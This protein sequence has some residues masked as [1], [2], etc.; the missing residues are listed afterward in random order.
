V[1]RGQRKR[2]L[3]EHWGQRSFHGRQVVD[4]ALLDSLDLDVTTFKRAAQ[5][6]EP[7][8]LHAYGTR[9]GGTPQEVTIRPD[10][11]D[12][13][14]WAGMTI[15][16]FDFFK[17]HPPLYAFMRALREDTGFTGSM[18]S[19]IFFSPP[20]SG[21][22][23]HFD[24]TA[25]INLQ[26]QGTKA[27]HFGE[28]P[29][30]MNPPIGGKLADFSQMQEAHSWFRPR[31]PRADHLQS[32]TLAPGDVLYLAPGTWHDAN[33]NDVSLSVGLGIRPL[34]RAKRL[35][36]GLLGVLNDSEEWRV[37]N[38]P[39][40]NGHSHHRDANGGGDRRASAL[41]LAAQLEALLAEGLEPPAIVDALEP[42]PE[43]P[44]PV[45]GDVFDVSHPFRFSP[46]KGAGSDIDVVT[47]ARTF[48]L[49]AEALPLLEKLART[50]SFSASD[51]MRWPAEERMVDSWADVRLLVAD[52]VNLGLLRPSQKGRAKPDAA[53][54]RNGA[55][56]R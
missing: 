31:V 12:E 11:I 39:A 27:W 54:V 5:K 35:S 53:R 32:I 18:I 50:R 29:A 56:A 25:V 19:T 15:A 49:G 45:K 47:S 41:A 28:A 37:E 2:F 4:R 22:A 30:V 21:Y 26:L 17:V 3:T 7:G 43:A 42:P 44:L 16:A 20:T 55:R 40:R 51:V 8:A 13:L 6:L 46:A 10:Q 24:E 52:L 14:F 48:V 9:P 38:A 23:P 36:D 34:T 1:G 33:A